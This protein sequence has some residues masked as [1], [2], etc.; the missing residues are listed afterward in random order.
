MGDFNANIGVRNIKDNM[1]CTGPFGTGNRNERGERLLDFAEENNLV[2]TNSFFFKAANR[3]WTWEASGGVTKN[4]IDF[5]LSSDQKIVR[6]CEVITKLDIG[7]DHRMLR[8]RA[9]IDKKLMRLQKIQ[10]QKPHRLDLRVL[11]K[12]ATPF[13]TELKNRFD[14]LKDEEPSI[15]K[16][17]TVLRESMDTIL[18]KTQKSTI[19]KSTEDTEI[20]NLHKK[21]KELRQKTNKTLKNQV[22]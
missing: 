10:K 15:E 5:I 3:Y 22:E 18:N 21:R 1:K 2:V 6:N 16:M 11:E 12:L 20:E 14:T 9:E 7:S 17:N 4:K 19:K 8:A 13:R